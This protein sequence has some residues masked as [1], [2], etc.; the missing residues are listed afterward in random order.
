[1]KKQ[2]YK[3][4]HLLNAVDDAWIKYYTAAYIDG[5]QTHEEELKHESLGNKY[6][7]DP[8]WYYQYD[9]DTDRYYVVVD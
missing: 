8:D 5:T 1:M 6:C 2:N 3:E 9:R 7:S 4:C